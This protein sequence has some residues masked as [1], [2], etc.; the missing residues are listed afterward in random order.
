MDDL[1]SLNDLPPRFEMRETNSLS[2]PEARREVADFYAFHYA[3]GLDALLETNWYTAHGLPHLQSNP[4]L[5]DFVADCTRQFRA[6]TDNP[7]MTNQI[8]SLEARLVWQLAKMP[9]SS[10][11]QFD[12]GT[13]VDTLENLLTGHFLEPNRIPPPPSPEQDDVQHSRALFWYNLALFTAARDDHRDPAAHRQINDSLAVMRRILN[14][15]EN[16]DVLYSFAVGRYIGGRMPGF[17]PMER[18]IV[19]PSPDAQDEVNKLKV[20]VHFVEQEDQKGTTQV[21]Q[22]VCSMALRAWA[23]QKQ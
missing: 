1:F 10:S 19:A 13:R 14:M 17:H 20:A 7:A 11:I 6:A 12:V 3:P 5:H 16:R 15:F 9:R 23:L 21:I 2:S 8:R 22:R 4:E 18:P